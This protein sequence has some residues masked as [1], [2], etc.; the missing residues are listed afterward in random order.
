MKYIKVRWIHNDSNEPVWLF[1]E[2]DNASWEIRKIEIFADGSCGFAGQGSE[3][4]G[5]SL[6]RAPLP[7]IREIAADSQFVPVEIE[8]EEFE[9]MWKQR[10]DH[11][12]KSGSV[13]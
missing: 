2:L 8:A 1:S 5:S 10:W 4:G 3:A 12:R 13:Q 9:Q 11:P 7:P 6:G